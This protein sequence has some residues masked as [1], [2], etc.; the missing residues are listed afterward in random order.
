MTADSNA[1]RSAAEKVLEEKEYY[2]KAC[3]EIEYLLNQELGK[4]WGDEAYDKLKQTYN[5]KHKALLERLGHVIKEFSD[6]LTEAAN[7]L[8]KTIK[9]LL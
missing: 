3:L 8:D 6:D 1:M 7:D 4:S 5:S 9:T 2:D